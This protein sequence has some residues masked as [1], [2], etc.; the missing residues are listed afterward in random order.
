MCGFGLA[1]P[2]GNLN[3]SDQLIM[4]HSVPCVLLTTTENTIRTLLASLS[5]GVSVAKLV[6]VERINKRKSPCITISSLVFYYYFG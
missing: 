3:F 1:P 5:A 6:L 4:P 2:S